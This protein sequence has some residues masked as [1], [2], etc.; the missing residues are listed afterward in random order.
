LS[1]GAAGACDPAVPTS[2]DSSNTAITSPTPP[3]CSFLTQQAA[4]AISGDTAVTNQAS[5]VSEPTSG[6]VACVYADTAKEGN[7]V[8]VQI[9]REPGGTASSA[10]TQAVTF[11]S[12][13]EPVQPFV[14]F[15]VTGVGETAL[16]EATPGV[17]FIVFSTANLLV[18][19][20]ADSAVV[21][22]A[23]LQEGVAH[24][25]QRIAARL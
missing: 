8:S 15:P 10:L 23:A 1:A 20:G 13:G 14:S 7:S 5:N 4:A 18:Y 22:G 9:K 6:Y 17:A 25:A 16:G 3:P 2:A 24:Q 19:V 11:F 12:R 21:S